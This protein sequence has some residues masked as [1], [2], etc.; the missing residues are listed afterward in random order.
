MMDPVIEQKAYDLCSTL[1]G[2]EWSDRQRLQVETIHGGVTNKLYLCSLLEDGKKVKSVVY[3]VYGLI[4]DNVDAQITESV[5]FSLLGSQGIGP[6]LH[7]IFPGGRLEEYIH[8][9][10]LTTA[11]LHDP[12]ASRAIAAQVASFHKLE[13]PVEKGPVLRKQLLNYRDKCI[14]LGINLS[15]YE[16]DI[17]YACQIIDTSKSPII[18][19]HNDVHEGNC[20]IDQRKLSPGQDRMEALRLID[21]EYS[22]Y[23]YR[24]FEFGN[25]FCEWMYDYTNP[26][27]PYYYHNPDHW[28]TH[29]QKSNF[30]DEYLK[31]ADTSATR[32]ELIAEADHF[33][34]VSHIYWMLWSFVQAEV[35]DIQFGYKEYALV[36]HQSYLQLREQI[37]V[38]NNNAN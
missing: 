32:D 3:R 22:N 12:A 17:D 30:I 36:R 20:L 5:V 11:D 8:G 33:A 13:M 21:F 6:K 10:N 15:A 2:K 27:A 18:F 34:L 26:E 29:E 24:G 9:S 38:S 7:G 23:G 28:P 25:H 19:C 1:L 14:E 37:K 35:S 31:H 4:M 16:A